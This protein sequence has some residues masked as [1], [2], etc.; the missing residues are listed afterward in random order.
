MEVSRC[1]I[2]NSGDFESAFVAS[3]PTVSPR[4][5]LLTLSST[6]Q[7][8]CDLAFLNAYSSKISKAKK[9]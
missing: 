9:I 1:H 3:T 6:A 7:V 2:A 4:C 8:I 5:S